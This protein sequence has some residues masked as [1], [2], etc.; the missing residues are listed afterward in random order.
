METYTLLA[1]D[2][3]ADLVRQED[4][5]AYAEVYRRYWA[6]LHRF[7]QRM[8][9]DEEQA[10]DTVQ[11]VF[12]HLWEHAAQLDLKLSLHS[13]LY[14]AARNQI[15]RHIRHERVKAQYLHQLVFDESELLADER[16][17]VA[18]L[19]R[20]VEREVENLPPKMRE[21]FELSRKA[22]L[23]HKEI[24]ARLNI[25]E[26]TVKKQVSN[27]LRLLRAKLGCYF[28]LGVLQG[29]V[30]LNRFLN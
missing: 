16:L 7:C 12:A 26:G 11:D 22:Y 13:Y 2:V 19:E 24:A 28:F 9:R 17:R 14:G 30:L 5:Q 20:L 21:V 15:I 18:E 27:A 29:L 4:R 8:L 1:D 10:T 25:S 3:L 6:V 23:T